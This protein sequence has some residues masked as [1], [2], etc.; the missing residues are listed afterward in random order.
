MSQRHAFAEGLRDGLPIGLGYLAVAFSLGIAARNAGLDAFQGFMASL[1]CI[2]SAGE[3]AGFTFIA[4]HASYLEIVL[5]SI[6]ANARYLLMSTALSQRFA[7]DTPFVHRI[8]VG[9]GITDE[10]FGLAIA[11]PGTVEPIYQ[12]GAMLS[13]IP[14]WCIGTSAGIIAGNLLPARVV[15]AL[16]A[17]LFGMFLAV[18]MPAARADRVVR[19][20]VIASFAASYVTSY[21]IPVTAAWSSGTRTIVLTVL[22]SAVAAIL[23][24][25]EDEGEVG[26]AA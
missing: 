26:H 22:I 14:L 18:I 2:A 16:S 7:P 21:L 12:Y 20:C 10:I 23:R 11:R 4:A 9:L 24:P 15:T 5:G 8:G 3:Y 6:V 17:S 19:V 13:S 25:V 1:L